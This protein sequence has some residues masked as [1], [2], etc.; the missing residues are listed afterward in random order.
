M[1]FVPAAVQDRPQQERLLRY[2][3][4][5][6]R[7]TFLPLVRPGVL[8]EN[9]PGRNLER[10]NYRVVQYHLE[11]SCCGYCGHSIAGYF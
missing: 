8:H 9:I 3:E 10:V 11:R 2:A 5:P 4:E 6:G 1:L 7:K